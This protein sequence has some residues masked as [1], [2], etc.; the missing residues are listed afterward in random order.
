MAIEKYGSYISNF[1]KI[2]NKEVENDVIGKP[3]NHGALERK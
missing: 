1:A 2:F 3:E